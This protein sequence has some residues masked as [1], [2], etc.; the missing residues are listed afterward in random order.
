MTTPIQSQP[1]IP[2]PF[3]LYSSPLCCILRC[4]LFPCLTVHPSKAGLLLFFV[5]VPVSVRPAH[6]GRPVRMFTASCWPS[7]CLS[8][9]HMHPRL[10]C[11]G[12]P[13]CAGGKPALVIVV[14]TAYAT[15]AAH[16]FSVSFEIR[17]ISKH[18]LREGENSSFHLGYSRPFFGV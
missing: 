11:E 6:S 13:I 12:W 7:L 15:G 1:V 5:S 16:L 4:L 17:E 9:S 3:A 18:L 2:K 10:L 8:D 14:T